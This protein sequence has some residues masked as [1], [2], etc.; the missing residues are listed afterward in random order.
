MSR[1]TWQARHEAT[2]RVEGREQTQL[3]FLGDSIF[4]GWDRAVYERHFGASHPLNL[5][6]GGDRTQEVLWRMQNGAL[7]GIR[8]RV[9]VLLIGTNNLGHDGARADEV[10]QAIGTIVSESKRR[11]PDARILLLAILPRE[12]EP[13]APAR[14]WIAEVNRRIA[15]LDDG[16]RVRFLDLGAYFVAEDGSIPQSLM[17]DYLH[18]TPK[19]YAVLAERMAPVL[20]ELLGSAAGDAPDGE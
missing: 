14:N 5:G 8:P 3:V 9:L 10:A 19:G 20:N 6:I 11:L 7:D 1:A 17:D 12:R 2:L 4:E 18:P 16:K 15:R 13:T